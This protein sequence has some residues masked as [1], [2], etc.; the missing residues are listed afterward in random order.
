[1]HKTLRT[2]VVCS[3]VAVA[4]PLFSSSIAA[5]SSDAVEIELQM[6]NLLYSDGRYIEAFDTFERVGTCEDLRMRRQALMGSVRSALK[7]AD[8][9]HAN[10]DAEALVKIAPQDG[11]AIALHGD[12][13]WA[14]G[15]FEEAE[16]RFGDA[17]AIQPDLSR[18]LHGQAR[19]L[20]SRARL[21]EALARGQAALRLAPGDA[22]IHHTVGAIYE[23]M[24]RYEDAAKAFGG[25][26]NLLPNRDRSSKAAWSRA[27]IRF[28]KAFGRKKPIGIDDRDHATLHTVPFKIVDEK[29]IIKARVNGR[30]AMDFV[31]D[32]GAERTVITRD[33]AAR[34]NIEA[35]A[36]TLTA[37]VGGMGLRGL[38]LARLD[39][40]EIG[41]LRINNVP[42]MVKNP[43]LRGMPSGEAESFSPLSVGLSMVIDYERQQLIIGREIPVE[44]VDVELP[45]HFHRLATVRGQVEGGPANFI[46]DTGGQVISISTETARAIAPEGTPRIPLKVYGTSGWDR[47][48]FLM[49]SVDLAFH[50][51]EFRNI[52]VVV[53]N[54]RAPSVL[55]G[56][57]LGGIV[58]HKFLSRYRV[59]IDLDRSVV[60]L[61][62]RLGAKPGVLGN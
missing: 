54:L 31:L 39:T 62:A 10:A 37:G 28:L 35:I 49:P 36:N 53:L 18:A 17:L 45:L 27:E 48:A 2:A 55:L 12:S 13:L 60:G 14:L 56:F 16:Q 25:Y 52:P 46:V 33:T 23:R 43:P 8:F 7:L 21:D 32:T 1:M 59:S 61:K 29:I 15:L 44:P 58:G 38:Q 6:G 20:A 50:E 9:T 3:A 22:E 5:I 41:D 11:E 51:I 40:L 4:L 57:R 19:S 34:L 26:V 30:P 24:H 42:T 47:D